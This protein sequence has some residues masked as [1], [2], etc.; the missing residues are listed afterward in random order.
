MMIKKLSVSNMGKVIIKGPSPWTLNA[1][2]IQFARKLDWTDSKQEMQ[3]V[4]IF[5]RT[6]LNLI[7]W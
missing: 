2:L 4:N 6:G 5:L 7:C 3:T 1:Q